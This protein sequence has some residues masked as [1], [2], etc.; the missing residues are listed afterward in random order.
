MLALSLASLRQQALRSRQAVGH[1]KVAARRFAMARMMRTFR[2]LRAAA[3]QRATRRRHLMRVI[4]MHAQQ[5]LKFRF[6]TWRHWIVYK[7][8]TLCAIDKIVEEIR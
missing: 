7:Q 3:L 4:G 5:E 2:E 1:L 6:K 8:M